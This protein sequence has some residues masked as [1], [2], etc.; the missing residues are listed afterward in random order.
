MYAEIGNTVMNILVDFRN[1]SYTIDI[2]K[3]LNVHMEEKKTSVFIPKNR[4]DQIMKVIN[5][6]SSDQ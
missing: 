1:F 5:K 6:S 4:Y 2:I 3:G